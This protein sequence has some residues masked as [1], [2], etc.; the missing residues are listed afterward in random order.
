MVAVPNLAR[1]PDDLKAQRRWTPWRYE[2]RK[3]GKKTKRPL[4]RT[5]KPD[6]WLSVSDAGDFVVRGEAD[7]IGFVL[8]DG[9]VGIDLD[10]CVDEDGTFH[11]IAKD[12]IALNTYTE[13]SPSGHGL[14]AYIR[15]TI[16]TSCN[17]HSRNGLPR[18][19]IYDRARYFTVTGEQVGEA[20]EIRTGLEAQA[21]LD[22]YYAKWFTKESESVAFADNIERDAERELDD[23]EVLRLLLNEANG[24]KWRRIFDGDWIEYHPS[25]SEADLA[26]CRKVYFYTRG[27]AVQMNRIL[28][29]SGLMRS[30]W[31]E[32]R[33]THTYAD[34]TIAAAMR[35]GGRV[36]TLPCPKYKTE[37]QEGQYGK[38]HRSTLPTLAKMTK[39]DNLVY[40]ALA[41]Y[42]DGVTG[43]C[44]PSA[45][46][47]ARLIGNTREH[48]Q[49]SIGSLTSV[50]L[51]S[52]TPR[53]GRTSIIRLL[54]YRGVSNFDTARKGKA[55][56]DITLPNGIARS[57]DPRRRQL[58]RRF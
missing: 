28:R 49:T 2:I 43:E 29:S 54:A 9:I 30:K 55:P 50:G 53:P 35:L 22:A 45:T 44:D 3:G 56:K 20:S 13:T 36:Y 4:L 27:N 48:V 6:E 8:G 34:I 42:A 11:E 10:D 23:D 12:L 21:A 33:G 14:H 31:D 52:V 19:E 25:Q 17:I 41:T 16:P 46:T 18:R 39:T 1:V 51:I 7:G 47:I 24:A 57:L 32:M 5:N 58:L 40:D 15:A 26:L 38:V 37:A